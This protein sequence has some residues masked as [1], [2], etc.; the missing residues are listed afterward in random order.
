M[1]GK[2]EGDSSKVEIE[3]KSEGD[4]EI[5]I[6]TRNEIAKSTRKDLLT[7]YYF[8][9]PILEF[10]ENIER[11]RKEIFRIVIFW[12]GESA[13]SRSFEDLIP[14]CNKNN[15]SIISPYEK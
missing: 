13:N 8:I 1:S 9:D 5:K 7:L 4:S 11:K 10:L 6:I 12:K 14:I 2:L 15:T 3:F